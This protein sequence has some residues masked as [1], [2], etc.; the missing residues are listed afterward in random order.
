MLKLKT[1][2]P[3]D[4]KTLLAISDA[5][6]EYKRNLAAH[7]LPIGDAR[8]EALRQ[9]WTNIDGINFDGTIPW[10]RDLSMHPDYKE[11][12][13]ADG[14]K[15]YSFDWRVLP[16]GS[17]IV[18]DEAHQCFPTTGKPGRS[19]DPV[20]RTMDEARHRGFDFVFVTQYPTKIH[21]E[22]RQMVKEHKHLF[23]AALNLQSAAVWTFSRCISDPYDE[24]AREGASDV[25][26]NYPEEL[27]RVYKSAT[28]HTH[29]FQMPKNLKGGFVTLCAIVAVLI[30]LW[31]FFRSPSEAVAVETPE[32]ENALA[33]AGGPA[34][35]DP[36]VPGSR[37]GSLLSPAEAWQEAAV[38]PR[39][40][41]C[42]VLSASCRCWNG[43]GEQLKLSRAQ[44]EALVAVPLP[45]DFS[46]D[47]L[48]RRVEPPEA[49][50]RTFAGVESSVPAAAGGSIPWI[51]DNKLPIAG[52][53]VRPAGL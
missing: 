46:Q 9:F 29:K 39:L 37:S 14:E 49:S 53:P 47:V 17:Y 43:A 35:G 45:I 42:A 27:F 22:V 33:F 50:V 44:C 3:G 13:T 48:E 25:L 11:S 52:S 41:G 7:A 20:I 24:K 30:G 15:R 19:D 5:R 38:M 10:F 40:K 31:L 23:R 28:V 34:A 51:G 1:G 36:L 8:H 4:G 2:A 18:Y 16:D 12:R 26:W 6:D 32:S 21:H